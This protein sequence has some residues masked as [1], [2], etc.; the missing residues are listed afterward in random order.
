MF[1]HA[2][3]IYCTI[4]QTPELMLQMYEP[5]PMFYPYPLKR[6][7]VFYYL[8]YFIIQFNFC[9]PDCISTIK[10][11]L[12]LPARSRFGEGRSHTCAATILLSITPCIP[13]LRGIF[14]HSVNC[15]TLLLPLLLER[16]RCF[17]SLMNFLF[18]HINFCSLLT[19]HQ[20]SRLLS[21]R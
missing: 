11:T 21:R 17:K 10:L 3:N 18:Y 1:L 15:L 19:T 9:V 12:R 14:L 8:T 13:C 5:T 20:S 6:D 7:F 4:L 2:V 16:E